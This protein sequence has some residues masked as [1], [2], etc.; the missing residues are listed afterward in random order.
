MDHDYILL[1][2]RPSGA[3]SMNATYG[4]AA[5]VAPSALNL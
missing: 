4:G 3:N 1:C 2:V 5:R